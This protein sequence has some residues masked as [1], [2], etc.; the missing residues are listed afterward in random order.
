[1]NP[2]LVG[3]AV[4]KTAYHFDKEY[5]YLVPEGMTVPKVG[6][7]VL[8]PF[9]GK[10]SF[11]T[12][13]VLSCKQ[14]QE[15]PALKP[16]VRVL[17]DSPLL[18]EE[19]VKLAFF[20]KEHTFCTLFD[21]CKT[22]LPAGITMQLVTYYRGGS[23]QAFEE[24]ASTL[25][26]HLR[27]LCEELQH[28]TANFSEETLISKYSL[29][30]DGKE[31]NLLVKRGLL[32]AEKDAVRRMG[33]ATLQMVKR[34]PLGENEELAKTFT[35]KQ[36]AVWDLLSQVGRASVKEVCYYTGV[37]S[38]VVNTM[39]KK[40]FLLINEEEV[41]RVPHEEIA[42]SKSEEICLSDAQREA[43]ETLCGLL[44]KPQPACALL[45]GV[46][47]SGKTSV[48]L[49]LIDYALQ[50]DPDGGIVVMVPE[51]SLTPQAVAIFKGR[52]GS[53]VAV[54]H[55]RLSMGQRLDEFK[56][57]K[58]GLATIVVGTRSAVFAPFD[59]VQLMVIDEEQEHT[60]K[61]ESSPRFHA[62]DIAR[63]RAGYH[64]ALLVLASATPSVESF[65]KAK[66]GVYTLCTLKERFGKAVLPTVSLVDMKEEQNNGNTT[67][68]SAPLVERLEQVLRDKKQAILLLN[69]R[70]YHT[71][72][73]CGECGKVLECEACSISMTYHRENN[74]VLCHYCGASMP[75]PETCPACG[76]KVM[77]MTGV[78]TQKAQEQLEQLLPAARILR[79]DA[80]T[81]L[82]R[83]SHEEKLE[84]FGKGEYDILIGT[85]MVAKGLDFPSVSLVGVL[86]ADGM[87]HSNDYRA[88]ERGFS[89]LTQVI[90]RAGR[91]DG[92]GVAVIQT[93]EP[94]HELIDLAKQQDYDAFFE[95][96]ILIRQ[97]MQY[98]PFC[99]ICMVGFVGLS[100]EKTRAASRRML[101]LI[102]Q[103]V[104]G[105]YPNL[106]LKILGP[107]PAL[108]VRV[109]GK[110][111]YRIIIKCKNNKDFRAMM[112]QA[113]TAFGN[114]KGFGGVTAYADMNPE[115]I[116]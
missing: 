42:K 75:L 29:S 17:D 47:G 34:T 39:A 46:T 89:L 31:L 84:A 79:M 65:A 102:K 103:S 107:S 51:I 12:G 69:R 66:K 20:M 104:K 41:Y 90:G 4:E 113:L 96:E 112:A 38:A 83:Y 58:K 49:K 93:A 92:E 94:D 88:Y 14:G 63:F 16:L 116:L 61:S 18:S 28:T 95:Q 110:F 55:S 81:T 35:K 33:D 114:E 13:F 44:Q 101:E 109:A 115:G 64:N 9:G 21:A 68:F 37:T 62:R 91:A 6:C 86:G 108:V 77:K 7:R 85:Q 76:G 59:K 78:G 70:G 15:D 3:V 22:M 72:L 5:T 82:S 111:R 10:N 54:F 8:V 87:L 43:Y 80:D 36:K 74:R 45:Y 105:T 60:Y 73:S 106:P 11:R 25:P 30:P 26:E 67:V 40:G 24:A 1:M 56:R 19:M 57:V 97:M 2:W 48:Y 98:P 53:K 52:Y 71:Y 100:E 27:R 99:D 50:Q 32:I 23:A